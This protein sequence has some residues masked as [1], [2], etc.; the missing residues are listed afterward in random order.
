M[1]VVP[2]DAAVFVGPIRLD[3][4]RAALLIS[5]VPSAILLMSGKFGSIKFFDLLIGAH[6]FWAIFSLLISFGVFEGIEKAGSYFV[7][8]LGAYLLGRCFI[9]NYNDYRAVFSILFFLML[10]IMPFSIIEAFT[11]K[12]LIREFFSYQGTWETVVRP[13]S[14]L[15]LERAFGPFMHPIHNVYFRGKCLSWNLFCTGSWQVFT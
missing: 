15:G 4:Y 5:V 8:S 13:Q 9:R 10:L 14:R 11:G 3:P 12:A 2:P 7:G 1:L 6:V